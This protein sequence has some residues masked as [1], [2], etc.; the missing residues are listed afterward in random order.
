MPRDE[1]IYTLKPGTEYDL[2]VYGGC[3]HGGVYSD[4]VTV[5][6]VGGMTETERKAAIGRSR[7]AVELAGE[8]TETWRT[9]WSQ[10]V[11]MSVGDGPGPIT[12]Y[13]LGFR[14]AKD[15]QKGARGWRKWGK[16]RGPAELPC[17]ETVTHL[18]KGTEYDFAVVGA[19]G[20]DRIDSPCGHGRLH[21]VGAARPGRPGQ[22][23]R[24]REPRGP[25]RRR[26]PLLHG[27][28]HARRQAMGGAASPVRRHARHHHRRARRGP[29]AR[30]TYATPQDMVAR[31]GAEELEKLDRGYDAADPDSSPRLLTALED[32]SAEIDASLAPLY[33]LPLPSGR[34]PLL[35]AVACEIARFAL[36]DQSV[37]EAVTERAKEAREKLARVRSGKLLVVD[38]DGHTV[39]RTSAAA[40]KGPER[41]MTAEN[42]EGLT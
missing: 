24:R 20:A 41:V 30:M 31:F 13:W 34:Y 7:P 11:R 12:S 29:Q 36:Y 1:L 18:R 26:R 15:R 3:R 42:L 38:S 32:A 33:A 21:R 22:R 25:H 16:S 37:P 35:R 9:E 28:P 40:W 5:R 10:A 39:A 14:P 19:C 27:A 2:A 23:C 4:P 6:M 17:V 8:P